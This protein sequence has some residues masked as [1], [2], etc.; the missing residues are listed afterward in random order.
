M[1]ESKLVLGLLFGAAG[2]GY[3]IY[4]RRQRVLMPFLA[5]V[6]LLGAP[7]LVDSTGLLVLMGVVLLALPFVVKL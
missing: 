3:L 7:Y 5:G 6:G 4:G 2:I 1:N